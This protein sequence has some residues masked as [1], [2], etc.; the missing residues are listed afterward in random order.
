[1]N[2]RLPFTTVPT[3]RS[4]KDKGGSF[5]LHE[6]LSQNVVALRDS[7]PRY[8]DLPNDTARNRALAKDADLSPSQVFRVIK[9]ELGASIDIVEALA[10]ALE[11]RPQD[12]LTP[13]FHRQPIEQ[14]PASM[15]QE[16]KELRRRAG[17]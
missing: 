12:L 13:Y 16:P 10:R 8:K 5:L 4:K 3:R 7:H 9:R 17:S 14:I 15:I 1:M 11:A 2:A 6:F